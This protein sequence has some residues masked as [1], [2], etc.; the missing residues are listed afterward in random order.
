MKRRTLLSTSGVALLG[1]LGGCNGTPDGLGV[2]DDGNRTPTDEPRYPAVSPAEAGI[3][4]GHVTVRKAVKYEPKMGSGGVLAAEGKQYVVATIE[5]DLEL[6]QSDF[7]FRT[8]EGSWEPGLP[9]NAGRINTAV[10]GIEGSPLGS[11]GPSTVYDSPYISFVVPSPLSASNPRIR[12]ESPDSRSDD[13]EWPIPSDMQTRLAAPEPRFELVSLEVPEEIDD[14]DLMPVSLTVK[15]VSETD[16]RFLAA[17]YW[18]TAR[19]VDDDEATI[20]ERDVAANDD[21]TASLKLNR[22]Y[23]TMG[24]PLSVTLS[25]RGHVS[26]EREVRV[27][28]DGAKTTTGAREYHSSRRHNR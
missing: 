10:A 4:I 26:A 14:A 3:V 18:P 23:A 8:G 25:V 27:R 1:L 15:N 9:N 6:D 13:S 12:Y 5:T 7:R 17:I 22:R 20:V 11:H 16:G 24:Y 19:V 28:P 2:P 21:A